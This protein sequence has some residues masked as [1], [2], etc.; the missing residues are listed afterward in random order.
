M[1]VPLCPRACTAPF[2]G[3]PVH[4]CICAFVR[5]CPVGWW[6]GRHMRVPSCARACTAWCPRALVPP[7]ARA[8]FLLVRPWPGGWWHGRHMCV[9]SCTHACTAPCPRAPVHPCMCASVRLCMHGPMPPCPRAPLYVCLRAPVPR[10]SVAWQAHVGAI[11]H[12]CMHGS[13]PPCMH[14][15]DVHVCLCAALCAICCLD[16]QPMAPTGG[17]LRAPLQ[18]R[19]SCLCLSLA[20]W[21]D[22]CFVFFPREVFRVPYRHAWLKSNC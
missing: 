8:Y 13:I 5:P 6:H 7:C 4:P 16:G 19:V 22:K 9:P 2:P 12:P 10:P 1:C 21:V 20:R 14:G 11:V 3:A 17:G 15:P 18:A